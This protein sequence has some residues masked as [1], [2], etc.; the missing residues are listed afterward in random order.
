MRKIARLVVITK[1]PT[2]TEKLGKILAKE[3]LK[4]KRGIVLALEG[5]L[6]GGKT[7]FLKGFAR[8]LKIKEKILSPTFILMRRFEIKNRKIKNFYHFDCY[9]IENEK[10]ILNLGFKKIISLPKNLV[11]VEWAEKIRKILPKNVFLIKF[12]ILGEKKREISL[13]YGK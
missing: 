12:K 3:V 11:A 4:M 10:E 2:Q 1:S 6:G 7:T 13:G 9:R 8:G 5:D